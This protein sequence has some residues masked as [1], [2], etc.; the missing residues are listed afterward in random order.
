MERMK[1]P[2]STLGA[3]E[4]VLPLRPTSKGKLTLTR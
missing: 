3:P 2:E 4:N 1:R